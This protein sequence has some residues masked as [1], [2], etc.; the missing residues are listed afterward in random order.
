MTGKALPRGR[1]A[2]AGPAQYQHLCLSVPTS[3]GHMGA[4]PRA[5]ASAQRPLSELASL[6]DV[7]L[8]QMAGT[9]QAALASLVPPGRGL[10]VA[11]A[12]GASPTLTHT[13]TP[14]TVPARVPQ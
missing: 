12:L 5:M 10:T 2:E 13:P 8:G 7:G 4:W 1:A 6:K 3:A 14:C 11:R 9:R